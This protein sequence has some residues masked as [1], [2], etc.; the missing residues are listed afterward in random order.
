MTHMARLVT[1]LLMCLAPASA[2]QAAPP[3][4]PPSKSPPSGPPTSKPLGADF[5]VT[6]NL[7]NQHGTFTVT[8]VGTSPTL[9]F[10]VVVGHDPTSDCPCSWIL[11]KVPHP[12][13]APGQK[14]SVQCDMLTDGMWICPACFPVAP[15]SVDVWVRVLPLS[16]PFDDWFGSKALTAVWKVDR[17]KWSGG[18]T[19]KKVVPKPG[20]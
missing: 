17:S 8:N 7:G 14:V 9:P 12:G 11:K 4:T 15:F 5:Q 2:L 3:S 20:P 16:P 19:I 18:P 1:A 6:A 10:K 13:L